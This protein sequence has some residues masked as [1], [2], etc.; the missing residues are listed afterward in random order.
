MKTEEI[1]ELTRII[2]KDVSARDIIFTQLVREWC[3]RPY[4]G[5][6]N[7]CRN[8][9]N[10]PLCPPRAPYRADVLKTYSHFRV[11]I[12]EF[13]FGKYVARMK[14]RNKNDPYWTTDRLRCA[15]GTRA[16]PPAEHPAACVPIRKREKAKTVRG[17]LPC[18]ARQLPDVLWRSF[19]PRESSFI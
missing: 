11:L 16:C 3:K 9:G 19:Q 7:G 18:Q 10:S 4:K 5:Y 12:A 17:P 15:C 14:E 1:K 2:Y 8:H 13:E 6:K